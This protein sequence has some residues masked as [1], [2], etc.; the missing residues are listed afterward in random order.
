MREKVID[1]DEVMERVQDDRELL[2]ELLEIFEED[3]QE[4]ISLLKGVVEEGGFE[5][6]KDI[7]HSMKGAAGNISAKAIYSTCARIEQMAAK[8]DINEIKECV[9]VLEEQFRAFREEAN[10]LRAIW[11]Q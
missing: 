11:A 10:K 8:R 9:S 4:K 7:T 1:L 6:I 2:E 3:H 5:Q